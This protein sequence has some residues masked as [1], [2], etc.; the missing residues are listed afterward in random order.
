MEFDFYTLAVLYLAY[1]VLGWVG[2]TIVAT[3]RG[4]SFVN[5]GFASGPFCFVYGLSAVV[6]A[7]G[8][9]DLR[10]QPAAQVR[11]AAFRRAAW[12]TPV[13]QHLHC[14]LLSQIPGQAG[15]AV[16]IDQRRAFRTAQGQHSQALVPQ[17]AVPAPGGGP[18]LLLV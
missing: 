12:I 5:R 13:P 8:F 7:V 16:H 9:S 14:L 3:V 2:E 6:M 11:K 18:H 1:S 17:R 10:A 4:K 15:D